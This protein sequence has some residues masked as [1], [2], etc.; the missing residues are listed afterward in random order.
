VIGEDKGNL[1]RPIH[2]SHDLVHSH[3]TSKT[4]E[5]QPQVVTCYP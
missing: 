3:W 4:T 1:R 5:L 2:M